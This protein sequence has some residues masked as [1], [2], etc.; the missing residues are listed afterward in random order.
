MNKLFNLKLLQN[1][2]RGIC[3]SVKMGLGSNSFIRNICESR[4]VSSSFL[5]LYSI[6]PFSVKFNINIYFICSL[7]H[8]FFKLT[9]FLKSFYILYKKCKDK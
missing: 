7:I 6:Y 1:H 5:L 2:E 8:Q 3:K 9:C 4:M